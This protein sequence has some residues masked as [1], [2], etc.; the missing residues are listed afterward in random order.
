[1]ADDSR[2]RKAL[3][4]DLEAL[5]DSQWV[6]TSLCTEWSVRDEL[7]H[8]TATAKISGATFFPKLMASGFSLKKMHANTSPSTGAPRRL[9][10]WPGSER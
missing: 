10:P 7:A 8:M 2:Q 9:G 4:A 1:M 5:T 3:A 6:T